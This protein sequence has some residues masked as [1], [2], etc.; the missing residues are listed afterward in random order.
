MP[1][2]PLPSHLFAPPIHKHEP[3]AAT[4]KQA[5]KDAIIA[6]MSAAQEA[7]VQREAATRSAAAEQQRQA[8]AAAAAAAAQAEATRLQAEK[9]TQ[10]HAAAG[11]KTEELRR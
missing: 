4:D 2:H 7:R 1:A 10:A 9:T 3:S 11:A 8:Q 5:E 6:Q